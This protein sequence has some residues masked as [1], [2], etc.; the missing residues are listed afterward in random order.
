ME[1]KAQSGV[2]DSSADTQKKRVEFSESPKRPEGSKE[3]S[4]DSD[5]DDQDATQEQPRPLRRSV[6]VTMPPT[7]YDWDENH[8]SFALVTEIGEPDVTRKRSRQM[9]TA[10][11][12]QLWR[13][14][15]SL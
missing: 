3:D 11:G 6:R 1:N 4:S 13:K 7:R 15:W 9:T 10:S 14:R 2:S 12:L 8:V 5:R